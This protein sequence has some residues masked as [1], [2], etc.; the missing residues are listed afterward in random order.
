MK[1]MRADVYCAVDTTDMARAEALAAQLSGHVG[2]LKIGFEFFYAHY[3]NGYRALADKGLPIFLDLKLHDIGL[4]N[5]TNLTRWYERISMRE[6][7][8]KGYDLF[9]NGDQIPKV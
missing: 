3:L 4:K 9:E 8:Q 1:P 2:G 7:V 5:F 6:A